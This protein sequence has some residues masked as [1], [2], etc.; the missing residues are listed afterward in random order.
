MIKSHKLAIVVL[1]AAM[2]A[3][4]VE[5]QSPHSFT[6]TLNYGGAAAEKS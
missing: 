1:C 6:A 3:L 2:A 5:A 4:S